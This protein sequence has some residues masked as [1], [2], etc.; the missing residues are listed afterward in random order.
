L[1]KEAKRALGEGEEWNLTIMN[2]RHW[3][4][5]PSNVPVHILLVEDNPADVRLV[6]E[7]LHTTAL[8]YVLEVVSD[9]DEAI[10][11][12]QEPFSG[13]EA[14][15]LILLD[16]NLPRRN[17]HEVL[18]FI[19]SD[20]KISSIP[21]I[22]MSSSGSPDDVEKAYAAHANCYVQKPQ[23]IDDFFHVCSL[24]EAFWFEV[25]KLPGKAR[26]S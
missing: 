3:D 14:P 2:G 10:S 23:S 15:D 20:P 9:G 12:L 16:L 26:A 18:S 8:R 22:V 11:R 13:R 1:S 4:N 19:K 25:A 24:L 6:H 7:A 17:G 21:T 5:E